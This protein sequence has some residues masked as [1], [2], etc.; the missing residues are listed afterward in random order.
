MLFTCNVFA[1]LGYVAQL[2]PDTSSK[3]QNKLLNGTGLGLDFVT[4]YDLVFR[5]EYGMNHLKETGWFIHFVA[6]I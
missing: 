5:L 6:P 4:Y 2:S 3:L 1:D